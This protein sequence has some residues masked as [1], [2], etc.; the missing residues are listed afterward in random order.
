M[1]VKYYK[2]GFTIKKEENYFNYSYKAV[3]DKDYI[4]VDLTNN[5]TDEVHKFFIIYNDMIN[6]K[7][8]SN[9]EAIPY[10]LTDLYVYATIVDRIKNNII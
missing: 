8:F 2:N 4:L 5:S 7:H 3:L 10:E 1:T 9:V 6:E